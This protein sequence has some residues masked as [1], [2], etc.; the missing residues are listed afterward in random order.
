MVGQHQ[1]QLASHG[2]GAHGTYNG[3]TM[4]KARRAGKSA[5]R[6]AAELAIGEGRRRDLKKKILNGV[7]DWHPETYRKS[8]EELEAMTNKKLRA[9]YEAQNQTLNDWAEVDSLVWSLADDVLDSM[10]PDADH[11]G[12]VERETPLK[13]TGDDLESFLPPEEREKRA[14]GHRLAKRAVNVRVTS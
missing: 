10:N 4:P 3:L 6:D 9:F 12:I 5:F 1:R 13:G 8:D 7:E 11:D 14:K 2:T